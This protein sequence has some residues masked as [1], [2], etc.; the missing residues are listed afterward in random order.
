MSETILIVEDEQ[1]L[2]ALLYAVKPKT[3]E[4]FDGLVEALTA[5]VKKADD[6]VNVD[7]NVALARLNGMTALLERAVAARIEFETLKPTLAESLNSVLPPYDQII[8]NNAE[9]VS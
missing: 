9:K 6:T 8:S 5:F 4:E 2:A 1:K 7:D 3:L